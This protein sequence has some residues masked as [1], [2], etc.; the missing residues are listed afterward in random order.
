MRVGAALLALL[1]VVMLPA[2]G[3][4]APLSHREFE[5]RATGMCTRGNARAARIVIPPFTDPR[6]A[7]A[8]FTRLVEVERGTVSQLRSLKPPKAEA[9]DVD[10]WL[11]L[12][13]QML[14]EVTLARDA[15]RRADVFSA[16]DAVARAMSLDE[17]G[18][19]LARALGVRP[20]RLGTL[21]PN[22]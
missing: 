10:A 1:V 7:A 9:N 8:A 6:G 3:G 11:A 14:D 21:V 15:L 5:R 19:D 16:L 4:S 2:C 18:R 13:D 17:R 22:I 20:C 12:L